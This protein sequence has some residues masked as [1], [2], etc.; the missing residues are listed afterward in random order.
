MQ[1]CIAIFRVPTITVWDFNESPV[2]SRPVTVNTA[3]LRAVAKLIDEG[4]YLPF[5]LL[6]TENTQRAHTAVSA[7]RSFAGHALVRWLIT[8]ILRDSG[9][10]TLYCAAQV[11]C[12][13]PRVEIGNNMV[14]YLN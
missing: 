10:H 11:S 14:L 5:A 8:L 1:F 13:G 4:I 6:V 9:L 12:S 3:L 7:Y 2:L